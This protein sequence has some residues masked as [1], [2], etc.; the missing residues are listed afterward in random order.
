MAKRLMCIHTS[1]YM[2]DLEL[3]SWASQVL[4]ALQRLPTASTSMQVAVFIRSYDVDMGLLAHYILWH[5]MANIMKIWFLVI[6]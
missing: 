1:S 2:R 3:K 4:L 5:N 6:W